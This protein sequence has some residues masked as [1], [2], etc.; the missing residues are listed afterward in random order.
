VNDEPNG[1]GA[2]TGADSGGATDGSEPVPA[3]AD[4]FSRPQS[5]EERS[6][7]PAAMFNPALIAVIVAAA[8]D[9]YEHRSGFPMP[10]PMSFLVPPMVLHGPTRDALPRTSRTS[11]SSWIGSE[12]VLAAGFPRRAQHLAPQV[13]EGIRFGVRHQLLEISGPSGALTCP[14][15]PKTTKSS[16]GDLIPI[17]RAAGMLGRI[18]AR[19]GGSADVYAALRVR[20]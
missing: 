2:I 11:L 19:A 14:T 4:D 12:A 7:V 9:Q 10:W 17:V 8:V 13:R 20:P 18:F 15:P 1:V 5:W 6:P 3:A 16:P